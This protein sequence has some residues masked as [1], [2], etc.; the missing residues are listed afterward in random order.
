MELRDLVWIE[1]IIKRKSKEEVFIRRA[2][3]DETVGLHY[4]MLITST[5]IG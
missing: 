3:R 1:G 5:Q 2:A 4:I